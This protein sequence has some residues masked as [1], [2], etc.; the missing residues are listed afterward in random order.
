MRGVGSNWARGHPGVT[1]L[2]SPLSVCPLRC[3][4]S[5]LRKCK[6]KVLGDLRVRRAWGCQQCLK[7]E[8]LNASILFLGQERRVKKGE[9]QGEGNW[10]TESRQGS[11]YSCSAWWPWKSQ[12]GDFSPVAG[13]FASNAQSLGLKPQH[14]KIEQSELYFIVPAPTVKSIL[15]HLVCTLNA[16]S[17]FI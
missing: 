10:G 3:R 15:S 4:G 13:V 9:R 11:A 1:I 17:F 6:Q 14:Y 5:S 12:T 2:S 16:R 7:L 8:K